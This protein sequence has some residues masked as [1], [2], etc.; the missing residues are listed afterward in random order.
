MVYLGQGTKNLYSVWCPLGDVSLELGGLA[1]CV[2]S[3]RWERVKETYGKTDVD[4]DGHDGLFSDDPLELVAN[5]GGQWKTTTYK[6]G[7]VLVFSM[8][9]MHAALTNQT[10]RFRLSMD[11]RFQLASEPADKRWIGENP[12]GYSSVF[13]KP[14][15]K[16]MK[17]AREEWGV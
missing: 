16:P 12:P 17:V 15:T 11:T 10:D 3:H 2:G 1:V 5:F 6:A 14:A 9:T 7:D 4:R 13:V 8:F